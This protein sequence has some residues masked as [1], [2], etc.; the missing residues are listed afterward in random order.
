MFDSRTF[1]L[2]LNTLQLAAA[3]LGLA[4]PTGVLLAVLLWRTD[5]PGRRLALAM[6][7][8]MLFIPLYLQ[9]AAWD[10]G[11]G[12]QGWFSVQQGNLQFPPLFGWRAVIWIHA[13]AAIPWVV[14]IVGVGLRLIEPELEELALLDMSPWQVV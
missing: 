3:T 4:L 7:T 12:L 9:A 13:L 8:A 6:L 14:L 2:A 10:A 11:F 1:Y 5:V